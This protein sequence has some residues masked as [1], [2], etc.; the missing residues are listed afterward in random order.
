TSVPFENLGFRTNLQTTP[1]PALTW[2]ALSK[3]PSVV[4]V[5]GSLL[6]GIW[7]ITNRREEVKE[8][9]RNMKNNHQST[10]GKQ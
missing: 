9:E 8:Y 1:L 3:I 7:W 4:T 10:N 5:G 2:N 6:F